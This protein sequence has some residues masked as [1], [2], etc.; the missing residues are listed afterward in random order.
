[1]GRKRTDE[2]IRIDLEALENDGD[3]LLIAMKE[4][5]HTLLNTGAK[6][7]VLA[8][9]PDLLQQIGFQFWVTRVKTVLTELGVAPHEAFGGRATISNMNDALGFIQAVLADHQ[10]GKLPAPAPTG[11]FEGAWRWTKDH[12]IVVV[13]G[14]VVAAFV[15]GLATGD[16][17][18]TYD[19]N[20]ESTKLLKLLEQCKA[21]SDKSAKQSPPLELIASAL[22]YCGPAD[23]GESGAEAHDAGPDASPRN[24]PV[25]VTASGGD[26]SD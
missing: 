15:A 9:P 21:P 20:L 24:S 16:K 8:P 14:L 22:N 1:V 23:A 10:D 12:S 2:E 6:A 17:L 25:P 19:K 18:A 26:A 3:R 7:G 13:G 4:E 11:K 5:F